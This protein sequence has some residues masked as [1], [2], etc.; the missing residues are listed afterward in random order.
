MSQHVR[1]TNIT[2]YNRYDPTNRG[3]FLGL[4]YKVRWSEDNKKSFL[5]KEF[6]SYKE[7]VSFNDLYIPFEWR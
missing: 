7:A 4:V 5:T 1:P 6:L 2:A 3:N